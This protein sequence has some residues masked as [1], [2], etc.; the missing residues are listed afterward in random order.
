MAKQEKKTSVPPRDQVETIANESG[1][2]AKKPPEPAVENKSNREMV[3]RSAA[4]HQRK[5]VQQPKQAN[6]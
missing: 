6:G 5:T 3:S 2:K 4:K 1:A